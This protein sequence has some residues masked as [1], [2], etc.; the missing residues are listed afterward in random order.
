V[1][2][3]YLQRYF[4][5]ILGTARIVTK[6]SNPCSKQTLILVIRVL[7]RNTATMETRKNGEDSQKTKENSLRRTTL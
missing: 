3:G 5:V 1:I 6:S 7:I 4:L 2:E